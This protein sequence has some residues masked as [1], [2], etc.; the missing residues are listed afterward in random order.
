[1]SRIKVLSLAV[2]AVFAL[3]AVAASSAFAAKEGKWVN[4]KGTKVEGKIKV[5]SIGNQVL[6]T[7]AGVKVTCTSASGEGAATST[8]EAKVSGVTFKGCKKSTGGTCKSG[9]VAEEIVIGEL[10]EKVVTNAAKTKDQVIT[11]IVPAV[12]FECAETKVEVAAGGKFATTS[13]KEE[14]KLAKTST[15]AAACKAGSPGVQQEEEAFVAAGSHLMTT[16]GKGA[17]E[18]SCQSGEAVATPA[19]EAEFL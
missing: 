2:L 19:E 15:L 16:I 9:T 7:K 14:G 3:T 4:S 13:V 6:E 17:A 8:T 10:T 12:K 5:A 11:T 1:M 18:E